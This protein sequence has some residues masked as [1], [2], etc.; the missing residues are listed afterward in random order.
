MQ[1]SCVPSVVLTYQVALE[2]T[3]NNTPGGTVSSTHSQTRAIS[4]YVI[5]SVYSTVKPVI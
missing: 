4:G 2:E 5:V 1:K 3:T